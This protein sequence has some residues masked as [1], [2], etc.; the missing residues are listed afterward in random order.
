MGKLSHRLGPNNNKLGPGQAQLRPA[1][2]PPYQ[3][4]LFS[5]SLLPT[6]RLRVGYLPSL[7]E[8][9]VIPHQPHKPTHLTTAG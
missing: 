8:S 7:A 4:G 3:T 5:P 1:W 9:W 2:L 6:V